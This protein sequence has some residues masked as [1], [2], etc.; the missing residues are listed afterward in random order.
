MRRIDTP[1]PG[2]HSERTAPLKRGEGALHVGSH[3]AR[4][5]RFHPGN[6]RAAQ[7]ER[8]VRRPGAHPVPARAQRLPAHRPRQGHLHR[9]RHRGA[10]RGEVQPPLRRHQSG[11]GGAGVRRRHPGG[12]PVARLRLGGPGVLRLRLLRADVRVG[13]AADPQGQGLR[14]RPLRG[15]DPR[16]PGHRRGG[17]GPGHR[18]APRAGQP[19]A[20]PDRGREPRPVPPHAR[21]ASSPTGPG[22]CGRRSTWRTPTCRCATP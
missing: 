1:A 2:S 3:A 18:H 17:Q 4:G 7:R 19:L 10:V 5:E 8:P 15:R 22:R 12:H 11:E 20:E 9:L 13:R 14:L 16:V 21:R 6:R